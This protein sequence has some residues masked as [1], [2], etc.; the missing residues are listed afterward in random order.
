MSFTRSD[1][2]KKDELRPFKITRNYIMYPEGSVLIEQGNT[3]VIVNASVESKVPPFLRDSNNGWITAEYNM[4][5]RSTDKR[6]NRDRN[7]RTQ[8]RSIEIQR[9]IGRS[10]RAAFDL[11]NIGEISIRVDCDVIQADGGT[12]CAS[13]TGAFVATFDAFRKAYQQNLIAKFP[14]Y[15]VLAAISVG[16]IDDTTIL[17]LDYSEDSTA[18]VDSNFVMTDD[19]NIVE[20]QGTS[21]RKTFDRKRLSEL[22]DLA[23]KGINELT[24]YQK[25]ILN[26]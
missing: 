26:L 22:L 14:D 21:E 10:I 2:R 5:P 17:D 1:G 23:E 19:K 3:K 9:L 20:I 12:R 11:N 7:G 25:E 24:I 6:I 4:L 8:S 13:I 15:K 18:E 16:I